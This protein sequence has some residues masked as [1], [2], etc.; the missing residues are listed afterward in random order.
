M[1]Q[2]PRLQQLQMRTVMVPRQRVVMVPQVQTYMVPQT[3]VGGQVFGAGG[4]NS[5]GFAGAGAALSS[6]Q[7]NDAAM[8]AIASLL[9]QRL[10]QRNNARS[11][12]RTL[13][14]VDDDLKRL[15]ERVD[16]LEKAI[17]R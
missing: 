5:F 9:Q 7:Q 1:E 11:Q 13:Q 16:A 8:R 4:V 3:V 15:T 14:Q 12:P 17:K 2:A 10:G 6:Q